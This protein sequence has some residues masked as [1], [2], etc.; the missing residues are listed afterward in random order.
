VRTAMVIR[1]WLCTVNSSRLGGDGGAQ[2]HTRTERAHHRD[3]SVTRTCQ[4][5]ILGHTLFICWAEMRGRSTR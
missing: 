4:T 1:S 2:V 5:Y 3:V